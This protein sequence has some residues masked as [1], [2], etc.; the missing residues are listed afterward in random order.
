VFA[1]F[2]HHPA[3]VR[4][5]TN[6]GENNAPSLALFHLANYNRLFEHMANNSKEDCVCVCNATHKAL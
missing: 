6:K 3:K 2:L 5:G 4:V 1:L